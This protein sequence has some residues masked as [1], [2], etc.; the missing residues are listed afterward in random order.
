MFS[1]MNTVGSLILMVIV[2]VYADGN[3]STE[4][5]TTVKP[6]TTPKPVVPTTNPTPVTTPTLAEGETDVIY[7]MSLRRLSLSVKHVYIIIN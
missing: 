4:N 7:M 1:R 6:K 3:S 5:P 2:S